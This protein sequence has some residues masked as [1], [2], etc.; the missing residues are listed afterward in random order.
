MGSLSTPILDLL[1]SKGFGFHMVC[2]I[3]GLDL[4]SLGFAFVDDIDLLQ[5]QM[6]ESWK[7]VTWNLQLTLTS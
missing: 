1:C 5:S 2:P 7:D 4:Y 6:G 3:S